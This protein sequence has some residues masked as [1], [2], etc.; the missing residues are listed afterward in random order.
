VSGD[1]ASYAEALDDFLRDPRAA[2]WAGLRPLVEAAAK[3]VALADAEAKAGRQIL[4]PPRDVFAAFRLTPLDRVRAVILG[5]DPYPTPGHAHGLAFS[6]G[7]GARATPASLRNILN[8][9]RADLGVEPPPRGD[10]TQWAKNGVLLLNAALTVEAGKAAAHMKWPWREV[11]R[12]AVSAVSRTRPGVAFLLWGQKAQSYSA[13]IDH[14]RHLVVAS[15]HPS[16]LSAYRGFIGSKPFSRVNAWLASHG[17]DDIPW[18][19]RP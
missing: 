14:R 6:A 1:P 16:P 12:E 10:L 5:Q 13:L 3:A 8:E 19:A 7:N 9:L 15:E 4:P 18:G 2:G 17:E 11:T